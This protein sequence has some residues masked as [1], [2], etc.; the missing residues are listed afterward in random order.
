[1]TDSER[2]VKKRKSTLTS[3]TEMSVKNGGKNWKKW[4]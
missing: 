2:K 1:M 3:Q 4:R